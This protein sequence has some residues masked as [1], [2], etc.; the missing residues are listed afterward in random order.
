MRSAFLTIV[1]FMLMPL[2]AALCQAVQPRNGDRIRITSAQNALE[3]RIAHVLSIRGDSLLLLVAPAETLAVARAGV[4]RLEVNT[5]RRNYPLRGAAIG[6]LIG[7]ASGVIMWSAWNDHQGGCCPTKG[8]R[9]FVTG[10]G[11]G[12]PGLLIGSFLGTQKVSERWTSVPLGAA[13]TT[14]SLQVGRGGAQLAVA[15]SFWP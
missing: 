14:P 9:M 11:L 7:L 5:G 8:A 3:N 10:V 15:V 12:V 4:T 1:A 13:E 6:A 2:G